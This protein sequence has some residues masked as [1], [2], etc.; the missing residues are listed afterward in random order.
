MDSYTLHSRLMG[1]AMAQQQR[2]RLLP[3]QARN[4]RSLQMLQHQWL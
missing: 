3:H 4:P 2:Q 1:L